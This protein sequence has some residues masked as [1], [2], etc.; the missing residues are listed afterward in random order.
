MNFLKSEKTFKAGI[1]RKRNKA[2]MSREYL[3]Q[4]L[5]TCGVS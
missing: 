3:S 2:A 5:E 1:Q 4:A